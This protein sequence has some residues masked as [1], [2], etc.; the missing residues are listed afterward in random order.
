MNTFEKGS[1][2]KENRVIAVHKVGSAYE[3]VVLIKSWDYNIFNGRGQYSNANCT[4]HQLVI[5]ART[6]LKVD[7]FSADRT[8]KCA[9]YSVGI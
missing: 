5:S 7:S 1:I 3:K 6:C 8:S 4:A 9:S 2:K